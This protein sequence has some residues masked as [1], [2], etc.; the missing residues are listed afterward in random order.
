MEL[1]DNTISVLR[2]FAQINPNVV[3]DGGSTIKTMSEARNIL[4]SAEVDVEFPQKLS[5]IHI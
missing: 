1:S 3:I 2:N 4:S 5:L